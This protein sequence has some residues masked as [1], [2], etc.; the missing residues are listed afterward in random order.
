MSIV[1]LAKRTL[2]EFSADDCTTY[3]Q[4]I[5]YSAL[6]SIF[7]LLLGAAALMGKFIADS[8]KRDQ[9]MSSIY[10]NI[11]AASSFVSDTLQS[12]EKSS[13][14][15]TLVA[16]LLLVASGRTVF[17]SIV[18]ALDIA[19]ETP[20]ER[21]FVQSIVLA[22][23][24]LFGVG[25][26]L[27]LSLAVTAIVQALASVSIL[28]FGPYK[29]TLILTPIQ[30][31]ISLAVSF[32][33]FGLLYK[34]APNTQLSW[35]DVAPGAGLAALLFEIAKLA[36]V[37]YVKTFLSTSAYGAIGGVIVL[38]TWCYFASI[39][40]LLGAELSSEYVKLRREEAPPKAVTNTIGP[41]PGP[42]MH[43]PA[44]AAPLGE[45]LVALG[46]TAIAAVAAFLAVL[47]TRR[48]S[49]QA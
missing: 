8:D 17:Q 30:F 47:G 27:V 14:S 4:A 13:G 1:T 36:F 9:V 21:G 3:A 24:L 23:E 46:A 28:G 20:A 19:F 7:P 48:P 12:A 43:A 11:P 39:I 25:L 35:R 45:R 15:L 26:L 49:G 44:K 38:L 31:L 22:F 10:A 40:L 29:D 41:R 16:A 37:I 32:A 5:A 42:I 18:H 6:C 33:M 34:W 2:K